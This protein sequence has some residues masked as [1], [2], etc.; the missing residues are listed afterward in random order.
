VENPH[1]VSQGIQQV[2]LDGNNLPDNLIQLVDDGQKHTVQIL[3]GT[4]ERDHLP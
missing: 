4:V 2:L 3:M 1:N